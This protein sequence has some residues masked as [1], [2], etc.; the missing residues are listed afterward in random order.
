MSGIIITEKQVAEFVDRCQ[1][2]IDNYTKANYENLTPQLLT[3]NYAAAKKF[4]RIVALERHV[5]EERKI[6]TSE[7]G[8]AWCFID[9]TN[10]DVLRPDGYK[11]PARHA[12]GNIL[13][14]D[15]GMS[16]IG[17]YGPAYLK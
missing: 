14:E 5:N 16:S 12:R 3:F 17:P 4:C 11:K 6:I 10:G 8:S 9:L 15:L 2:I 1:E 13:K 7:G